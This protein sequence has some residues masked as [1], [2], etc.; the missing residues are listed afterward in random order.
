MARAGGKRGREEGSEQSWRGTRGGASPPL[1]PESR[2]VGGSSLQCWVV[3]CACG[4]WGGA[5]GGWSG[6]GCIGD[7]GGRVAIIVELVDKVVAAS[8][9]CWWWL[10]RRWMHWQCRWWGGHCHWGG[11]QGG[12]HNVG[13]LVVACRV[14]Q[15]VVIHILVLV[16]W[17][18]GV[19]TVVTHQTC[20]VQWTW[21]ILSIQAYP[22]AS[23]ECDP[24]SSHPSH[25][26]QPSLW[27][28]IHED[29]LSW[30]E[31]WVWHVVAI[32]CTR[33]LFWGERWLPDIYQTSLPWEQ[34]KKQKKQK[35]NGRERSRLHS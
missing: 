28:R 16:E 22:G 4:H 26:N 15:V 29:G 8:R 27:R 5:G 18:G 33:R 7:T 21:N 35:R 32:H 19:M 2:A 23:N 17:W 30:C 11:W 34:A 20:L 31:K 6:S 1:P 3:V 14:I 13:M 24:C 10:V 25:K 12:S 9:G